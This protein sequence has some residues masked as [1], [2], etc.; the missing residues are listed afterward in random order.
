V[1]DWTALRTLLANVAGP[2]TVAW[3]DLDRLVGGL[4]RS[5][6]DHRA[7]W[8]GS[9]SQWLG[10]RAV[11][12]QVGTSV[13]FVPHGPSPSAVGPG[14]S[15]RAQATAHRRDLVLVGCVKAKLRHP[16]PAQDLYTSPLFREERAYAEACGVPWF[17]LSA[18][19]GLVRPDTVLEP[20]DLRLSKTTPAYRRAWGARV[21]DQLISEVGSLAGKRIEV[22]A[23]SAYT[24]AIRNDLRSHGAHVEEPL[25]GLTMGK[26]LA[27]YGPTTA[28][29]PARPDA[30]PISG[31]DVED[32]VQQLGDESLAQTPREFL[33]SEGV[34]LRTAGLYS[35]W[36]DE[37]GATDLSRGLQQPVRPGLIY[38][39]LAGAT[40]SRSGKRSTNTLWGRIRG[41]HLGGRHKFSTFRLSLG[42]ILARFRGDSDID[43]NYV[44]EWMHEH[45]RV[46]PITVEDPDTLGDV[47]TA[48]LSVLDP[49]LNLS[50]MPPTD[51]RARLTELR[52]Q[53]SLKGPRHLTDRP[54]RRSVTESD[55]S[56]FRDGSP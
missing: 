42:A 56:E 46:V 44:T 48:V 9:R 38:A 29:H 19:H 6:Y 21:V 14:T 54:L 3:A 20:Y 45:L 39:G 1:A 27:W 35:W 13:T 40:R 33:A 32:L 24:D 8:A 2:V 23:G 16:A 31:P 51:T 4:P 36:V 53:Y 26:R 18:E 50:K 43:E 30:T 22:H 47:E 7:F 5:A 11:D 52:R 49:P 37:T 12:V 55:V 34:G 28:P 10:F 25:S 41:M 17:I 15:A